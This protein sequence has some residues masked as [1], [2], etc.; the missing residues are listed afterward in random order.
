MPQLAELLDALHGAA[1]ANAVEFIG[2]AAIS[3]DDLYHDS[4]VVTAGSLFACVVG[5]N[6]DGHEHVDEARERGAVAVLCE[7]RLPVDMA[8]I[9]VPSVR[10]ALGP[11]AA[12]VHG[13]PARSMRCA[14]ITGTNGKTTTAAILA[15]VLNAAGHQTHVVGTLTGARTTPEAPDLHRQLAAAHRDGATALVMEVS[16][17]ALA[18][19]RVDALHFDVAVFTNLSVDHLDF[20]GSIEEYFR[21]KAKLFEPSHAARGV[22]NLDDTHGR[23]LA[24]AAVIPTVGFTRSDIA[25]LERTA[26]ATGFTWHDRAVVLPLVGDFNADNAHAAMLAATELGVDDD[27]I[28]AG[29]AA[30]PPI[31][32]RFERIDEGQRFAVVV[33]FAHTPDGLEHALQAA[34]RMVPAGRVLVVFGAGGD[35]DTTKRPDMGKVA[36]RLADRV[37]VT[38]DN[39]RTEDPATITSSIL[40][41]MHHPEGVTVE[42]DRTAAIALAIREARDGDV[43][44]IAGKGHEAT[45]TIGTS[46]TPFDDR[47]VARKLLRHAGAAQ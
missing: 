24:D 40:D 34:R 27:T 9:V 21:A 31:P 32:G 15:S 47:D 28:V 26:G 8:Q 35:R 23:L 18:L 22:V 4:R 16:S 25:P 33:D 2:D 30:V 7:R 45:Q 6:A 46:V 17:H 10:A 11:A 29:I 41:G 19:G 12:W 37:I 42:H 43:V 38:D 14:G 44:L 3:V 39:P 20:H 1:D 36:E 13:Y 5:E